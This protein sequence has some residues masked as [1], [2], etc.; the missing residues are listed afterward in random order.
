MLFV[1]LQLQ[2]ISLPSCPIKFNSR[3][4]SIHACRLCVEAESNSLVCGQLQVEAGDSRI[5]QT[6]YLRKEQLRHIECKLNISWNFHL[7]YCSSCIVTTD[8]YT[9]GESSMLAGHVLERNASSLAHLINQAHWELIP[10][11]TSLLHILFT[12]NYCLSGKAISW[13]KDSRISRLSL[14][15][16]CAIGHDTYIYI[17][18]I[19]YSKQLVVDHLIHAHASRHWY[20]ERHSQLRWTLSRNHSSSPYDRVGMVGECEFHVFA[21]SLHCINIHIK[22]LWFALHYLSTLV[23]VEGNQVFAQAWVGSFIY[24]VQT[25]CKWLVRMDFQIY[26]LSIH[27]VVCALKAC[28]LLDE[29]AQ[30]VWS[31][32]T[33]LQTCRNRDGQGSTCGILAICYHTYGHMC[34]AITLVSQIDA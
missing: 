28:E 14:Q 26:I 16:Q 22:P 20:E 29:S 21:S 24:Y 1:C 32:S 2:S 30:N 10:L 11:S 17:M 19:S 34:T 27:L 23:P 4:A 31:Q 15:L 18:Y 7:C 9:C 5:Y 3:S 6:T 25:K 33:N 13:W 12:R 8:C